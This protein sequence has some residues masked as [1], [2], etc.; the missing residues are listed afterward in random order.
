MAQS[1]DDVL[2]VL[3][4]QR[5]QAESLDAQ[6]GEDTA[7]TSAAIAGATAFLRQLRATVPEMNSAAVARPTRAQR[8][9]LRPWAE[10]VAQAQASA[11]ERIAISDLLTEGEISSVSDQHHALDRQFAELHQLD[12]FDWAICGVAGVLAALVDIFLVQVPRHPGFLGGQASEGGW[13]SNVVKERVGRVLP[14][15][16]I[17]EL[18]QA[19]RVSYDAATSHDLST[20]V[21]GLGPGT[22]R[23]Q[24]LGHDPILGWIFGVRDLLRGE[25]TAIGKDGRLIVQA[26]TEPFMAG[27]LLSVRVFEALRVVAGHLLSDLG[28]PRGLPAPLTPLLLF[29]Q[30][31]TIGKQ[32]YTVGEMSRQMY[33]MGYDFRHFLASSVHVLIVE[34]VVRIAYFAKALSEG[35]SLAEAIPVASTPKLRTQLFTAHL[36]AA[37]TNA[38]KVYVMQNPLAVNWPQWLAFFR[39]LIPQAHWLL[40]GAERERAL[41]IDA[42]LGRAWE[43]LDA[44]NAR[45]WKAVFGDTEPAVL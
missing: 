35:R 44:Q 1:D 26:T 19:Y 4:Q 5:R 42:H 7:A 33:R 2:R 24:S 3:L 8:P 38:G 23:F 39:Y 31:G 15:E 29:L 10:L 21:P 27:E 20:A 45:L 18:E 14:E 22:H 12:T 37:A 40:V 34:A 6:Q 9:I 11:P 32:Q 13:L 17:R 30:H 16:R 28:T 41:H 36:V 43:E 25:F